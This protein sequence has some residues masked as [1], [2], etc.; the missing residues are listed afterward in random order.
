M[1]QRFQTVVHGAIFGLII[2][3]VLYI[4]R[5]VIIPIVFGVLVFYVIVGLTRLMG[6]IPFLGPRLPSPVRHTLSIV[7][8][9]IALTVIAYLAIASKNS[10]VELAPQYQQ[11]L[12]SAI[13]SMAAFFHMESEPTWATLRQDLL[14]QVNMQRVIGA[15][16]TS[17]TSI[18]VGLLVVV[19]YAAL[20]LVEQRSFAAKVA[21][22]SSDPRRV[23]RIKEV[24]SDINDRIGAYLGMK[25]LLSILLGVLCWVAMVFAGLQFPVFWAV[26]IGLLN[27]VPYLGSVLGVVFPVLM[28]VLQFGWTGDVLAILVPLTIVQFVIGNIVDPLVMSNSLNLSPFA[29]LASLAVWTALWGVPGAFLAVPITAIMTIV[30]SEFPGTRP[31]AVLLSRNGQL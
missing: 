15:T 26:F 30:F 24:T 14:A 11:S 31:I 16:V 5:D 28:A 8:I 12:L 17:V 7:A 29:I 9:G 22:L 3:W 27:F 4:G 2:G 20:L 21:N 23:S 13:Q 10:L 18:V 25:T 6:R 19:L 1:N